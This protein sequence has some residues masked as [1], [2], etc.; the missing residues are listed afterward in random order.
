MITSLVFNIW[1]ITGAQL[2]RVNR[3]WISISKEFST[4]GCP[5]NATRPDK[6]LTGWAY[7]VLTFNIFKILT[8]DFL[9]FLVWGKLRIRR[10]FQKIWILFMQFHLCIT[11][12]SVELFVSWLVC[13]LVSWQVLP[14][15]ILWTQN[16]LHQEWGTFYQDTKGK[17]NIKWQEIIKL[18]VWRRLNW[19]PLKEFNEVIGAI[20]E[21]NAYLLSVFMNETLDI[22]LYLIKSSIRKCI[23]FCNT[24]IENWIKASSQSYM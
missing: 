17:L 12:F 9:L 7:K 23:L 1:V 14:I 3:K 16:I 18:Q 5:G 19:R 8:I 13:W 24:S 4:K 21:H 20:F 6:L 22:D 2:A 10:T 15:W 11:F